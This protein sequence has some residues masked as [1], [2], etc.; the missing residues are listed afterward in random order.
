MRF[1]QAVLGEGHAVDGA[2]DPGVAHA[3]GNIQAGQVQTC[4]APRLGTV[5]SIVGARSTCS[6]DGNR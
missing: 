2:L 4:A 5:V 6:D 1:W 3:G